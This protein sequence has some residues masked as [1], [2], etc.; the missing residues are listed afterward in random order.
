MITQSCLY[1]KH[2][3]KNEKQGCVNHHAMYIL[4]MKM[5][6][7]KFLKKFVLLLFSYEYLFRPQGFRLNDP[8][9]QTR[10]YVYLPAICTRYNKL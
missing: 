3:Y 9:G 2:R 10:R 1:Q 4:F 6:H 7:I 8:V 5:I